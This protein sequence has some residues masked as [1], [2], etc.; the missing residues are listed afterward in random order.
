KKEEHNCGV[1]GTHSKKEEWQ[2]RARERC[3]P[4]NPTK[5]RPRLAGPWVAACPLMGGTCR[6]QRP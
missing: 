6:L 1:V 5:I 2:Q 3:W 4:E